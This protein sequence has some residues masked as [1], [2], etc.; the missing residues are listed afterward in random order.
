MPRR[1]SV[2]TCEELGAALTYTIGPEHPE[3]DDPM[4]RR[5]RIGSD[6]LARM[7]RKKGKIG[8][9]AARADRTRRP[10]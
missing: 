5:H 8:T 1:Q 9:G 7:I 6:P 3:L 2:W 10:S 4:K